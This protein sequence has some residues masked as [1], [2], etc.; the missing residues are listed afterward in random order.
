MMILQNFQVGNFTKLKYFKV[1]KILDKF[2]IRV[3]SIKIKITIYQMT[4]IFKN[5]N[6]NRY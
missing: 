6:P 5:I 1:Q 3:T 4:R 2:K